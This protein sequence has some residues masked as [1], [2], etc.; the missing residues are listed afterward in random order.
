MK[1]YFQLAVFGASTAIVA[2]RCPNECS[3]NGE[4][5]PS[6]MCL[7]F[8]GYM[9]NDCS[10]RQCTYSKAY[11]DAPLG[12]LNANEAIDVDQQA[13]LY[14][15]NSPVGEMYPPHYGLARTNNSLEWNEAHFYRECAN[16]GI[17]DRKS[18]QCDCFP[19]FEGEGCQRTSCPSDCNGHGQCTLLSYDKYNYDAWDAHSTQ[20]CLCDPGYTGPDCSK[21]MCPVN[22][23]PERQKYTDT[24]TIIKIEFARQGSKTDPKAFFDGT[25]MLPNGETLFTLT[26]QDEFGDEY[27]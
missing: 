14:Q 16:K 6:S 21:R 27:V 7:C 1:T 11:V 2:A 23:D 5:S 15:A 10:Q 3:G 19:G 12:D 18:G 26:L 22:V 9:G 24:S 25:T 4:C 8:A 13:L 17:C 20:G